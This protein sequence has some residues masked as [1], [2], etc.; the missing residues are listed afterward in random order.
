VSVDVAAFENLKLV[1]A[2]KVDPSIAETFRATISSHWSI[3][4]SYGENC[5]IGLSGKNTVNRG[6]S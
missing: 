4:D 5:A 2:D 1:I 6:G 3:C